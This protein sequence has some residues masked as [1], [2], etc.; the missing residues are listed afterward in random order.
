MF[1]REYTNNMNRECTFGGAE[2]E[3]AIAGRD[4]G[5]GLEGVAFLETTFFGIYCSGSELFLSE[6]E[7][8]STVSFGVKNSSKTTQQQCMKKNWKILIEFN[9]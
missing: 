2:A 1:T 3:A 6:P 4:W 8:P 9:T 5:G 7:L